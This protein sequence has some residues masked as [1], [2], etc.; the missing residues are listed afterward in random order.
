M[1]RN[2]QRNALAVRR[3]NDGYFLPLG[4]VITFWSKANGAKVN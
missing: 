3:R 1:T 2:F 4:R